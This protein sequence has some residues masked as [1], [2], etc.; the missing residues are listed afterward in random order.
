[1]P[2][3]KKDNAWA[4]GAVPLVL[5]QHQYKMLPI[6]YFLGMTGLVATQM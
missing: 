2:R 5:Q 1:M 4:N 3:H 6:K